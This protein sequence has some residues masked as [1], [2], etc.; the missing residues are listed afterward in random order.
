[1]NTMFYSEMY[2]TKKQH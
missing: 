2:E 1:M